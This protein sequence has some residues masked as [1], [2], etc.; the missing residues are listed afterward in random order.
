VLVRPEVI[1]VGAL[2]EVQPVIGEVAR[3][4]APEP[5]DMIDQD[6]QV[7]RAELVERHGDD[8]GLSLQH[9]QALDGPVE[10]PA[11]A[12]DLVVALAGRVER[13]C[14]V[15]DGR[16]IDTVGQPFQQQPVGLHADGREG[17]RV[18]PGEDGEEI[19][20]K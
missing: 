1:Q 9:V 8:A 15:S 4:V 3:E 6:V 2:Q 14:D 17:R 13:D 7:A 5:L 19:A 20:A 12:A 16:V 18:D 11:H 10:V